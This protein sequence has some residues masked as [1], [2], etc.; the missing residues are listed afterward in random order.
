MACDVQELLVLGKCLGAVCS[1]P[2]EQVQMALG[3]VY[4]WSGTSMTRQ[5]LLTFGKC[6]GAGCMT[7]QEQVQS[8]LGFLCR[9]SGGGTPCFTLTMSS[10][11]DSGS[12]DGT[13][14]ATPVGGVGPFTYLWSD[15]QT[16]QTATGLEGGIEYT[17]AV[18]DEGEPLCVVDGQVEVSSGCTP[19]VD[20]QIYTGGTVPAQTASWTITGGTAADVGLNA[21]VTGSIT[22]IDVP[23]FTGLD[24]TFDLAPIASCLT[25]FT[26]SGL[27][28]SFVPGN[29]PVMNVLGVA[30]PNM[31]TFTAGA[32][33]PLLTILALQLNDNITTIDASNQASMFYLDCSQDP[34]LT[35]LTIAGSNAIIL[36][37]AVDCALSL[38]SVNAI[39]VQ[40]D[41]AGLSGG[42]VNLSAGTSSTPNGAGATA[43]ASLIGKGWAVTTN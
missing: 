30:S 32:G 16:T 8:V 20:A 17:V 9:I 21:T 34:L 5:E 42:T 40:L 22:A 15:A 25:Q 31:L 36:L 4:R 14:T 23:Q 24:G 39:L 27:V 41:G 43:A 29:L 2:Q 7:R 10:T 12:G 6:F 37:N 38:V 13:A 18:T 35:S 28:S 33:M 26:F 11:P 3:L 1:T 19:V